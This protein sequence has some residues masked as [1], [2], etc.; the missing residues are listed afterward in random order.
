MQITKFI[1]SCLLVETPERVAVIDPG[2]MSYEAFD[3][4]RLS[5]LNDILISHSHQDHFHLPFVKDLVAKF[6]E[7]KITTTKEVVEQL[8]S[9]G[10]A[11]QDTPSEG[12]VFFDS[13]HESVEPIF[14]TP[15]EVGI[16]YLDVLTIPGDSH[17]FKETKAILAIP[18]TAPWG[19]SIRAVNLVLQLKPKYVIP[20][21]DWHWSDAAR[22]SSY[23]N[24]E[25][26]LDREGITFFKPEKGQTIDINV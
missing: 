14:P 15:Q 4:N 7:V 9:E 13:P 1:H 17:S 8:K 2:S 20:V 11:A 16:H 22:I 21:H 24:Y 19:S 10:I 12:I 6:P 25:Q 23:N 18:I 26:V 3:L 5:R